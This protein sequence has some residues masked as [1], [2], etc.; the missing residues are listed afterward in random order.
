[1]AYNA[2][3]S[4]S[5]LA[6]R[7]QKL[8]FLAVVLEGVIVTGLVGAVFGLVETAV[9]VQTPL[10]KTIPVY[11]ALFVF[12]MIFLV[13]IT[14]DA[15]RL[16]NIIQI[17]GI[18]I[19]NLL[20]MIY[21]TLQ[22]TQTREALHGS[23]QEGLE[24]E[25]CLGD[26]YLSC[27]GPDS[28]YSLVQKLLVVVP[29]VMAVGEV[30]LV[31]FA[32]ALWEDFGWDVFRSLGADLKLKNMYQKLQVLITLLKFDIFFLF[33]F[34]GQ[35]IILV[36]SFLERQGGGGRAEFILTIV[37]LPISILVTVLC[38]FAAKREVKWLMSFCLFVFPFASL[39]SSLPS[40][41]PSDPPFP[42]PSPTRLVFVGGMAYA[43]YK[44]ISLFLPATRRYFDSTR[45]TL[46]VFAAFSTVLLFATFVVGIMCARNFGKGLL[47]AQEPTRAALP[48][49]VLSPSGGSKEEDSRPDS[50]TWPAAFSLD[51]R[52]RKPSNLSNQGSAGGGKE[53]PRMVID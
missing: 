28:L 7:A 9:S 34:C 15:M 21:S 12:A 16:R 41:H 50:A 51:A 13:A 8:F 20:L 39:S 48:T 42:S 25:D 27:D 35:F 26:A 31:W 49:F 10:L 6:T 44:F 23:R 17:V 36:P 43:I 18:L 53:P 32:R 4:P 11:L 14:V 47:N 45:R 33:G 24:P 5:L 30:A 38:I 29:I 37:A 22:I 1:M 2:S 40:L 3:Y 52:G 19:F 46:G